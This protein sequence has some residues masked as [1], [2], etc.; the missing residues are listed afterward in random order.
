MTVRD[1]GIVIDEVQRVPELFSYIQG[2][3]DETNKNGRFIL[4]GSQNFLLLEQISQSLAGRA[5]L[6]NLLSFSISEILSGFP[7]ADDFTQL[8]FTGTYPRIY[9]QNLNPSEWYP[10]YI[11]SYI[12]RDVRQ[13]ENIKDLNKFQTFLRL[14][15]GRVGQLLNASAIANDIGVSY[16]TI[17]SWISVLEAS[18]IIFLLQPFYRNFNKRLTKSPKLYFYDTGLVCSLLGIRSA[19]ELNFHYLKG[20]IFESLVIS[21]LK[22]HLA[23]TNHPAALYFWRD[24]SSNE[25]DC[26]I[27]S[28]SGVKAVEIKSS[29]TV[30]PAFFKSLEYWQKLTGTAAEHSYLVYGGA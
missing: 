24:K 10:S 28:G 9:D 23:N 19:E 30:N 26:L 6:F 13:I 27:D 18:F 14:C 22:K 5:A 16:K 3:V 4:T 8:A 12:E 17:Q 25:I 7:I 29:T 11:S 1:N 15:A 20:E 2:I 21:E